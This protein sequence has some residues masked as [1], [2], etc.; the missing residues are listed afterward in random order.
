ME[1]HDLLVN[2]HYYTPNK[3]NKYIE[4]RC[5]EILV[6]TMTKKIKKKTHYNGKYVQGV[7]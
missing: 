3:A 1:I 6:K 4:E 7:V 5:G 2:K